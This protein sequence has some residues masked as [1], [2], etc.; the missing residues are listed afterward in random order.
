MSSRFF[1][2]RLS[3]RL[4]QALCL[5]V[6][7]IVCSSSRGA[8]NP[9]RPTIPD[10]VF[11]VAA[12]KAMGD[13][14]TD[15]TAAI[16]AALDAANSAG[17]GTVEIPAG[18]FLCGP[19]RFYSKINFLLSE[20]AVLRM[21]PLDRYPGGSQNPQSF[22]SG[23]NLRDVAITGKGTIDGQGAAWWPHYKEKGFNRPRMI[24]LGGCERVL[25]EGVTL[26]NSPMFH[27]AIGGGSSDVIVKRVTIRAPASRDSDNPSHN[28]DACDVS[29][30]NILIQDCDVSVGDDN[31]T[32]GGGTYDVL[33]TN[34]KYGY[35]HG[36][37]IG[38]PTKGGVH[39]IT[40]THCTF[41][42]TE[43]GIRIK[44][45]RDRGGH[46]RSLVYS[47]LQ[48]TNV[49]FPILVY[50]AYMAKE[51]EFRDLT[52]L[53]PEI[54]KRYA[55]APVTP[56]TPIYSD[57]VF[58]NITATVANGR[59]AG[60]IWG[61]PESKA[62]HILLRN[63]KITADKPFGVYSAKEVRFENCEIKTPEGV[64]KFSTFDAEMA[65][66]P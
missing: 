12:Y 3:N 38:S 17:G 20:G 47:D 8:V 54:V 39:D 40:V 18:N 53:S 30:H 16:Q 23:S 43:C 64:N 14:E 56:L 1:V 21:L 37:S 52:N 11:S 13:G 29:G 28:S 35:G 2:P 24:A 59:R 7:S 33:I 65:V 45:D 63:V 57:I 36:V 31:F 27:I 55:A 25:I 9:A 42:N 50:A 62:T 49:D 19:L 58:Q 34:C 22:I 48:M 4:A 46:L 41:T 61:L 32:C 10:K 5:L 66:V 60:L 44:T 26:M 51:R 15:N 6:F